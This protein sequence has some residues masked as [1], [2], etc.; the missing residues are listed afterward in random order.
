MV[1]VRTDLVATDE[2]FV[3]VLADPD[4]LDL[5]FAEVLASWEAEPP[6]PERT[7]VATTEGRSPR[8]LTGGEGHS[9]PF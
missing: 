7:L 2:F 9:R 5:A 3:L 1:T 8:S 4:L 6:P